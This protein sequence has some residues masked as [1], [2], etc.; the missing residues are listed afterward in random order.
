MEKHLRG[1]NAAVAEKIRALRL[2]VGREFGFLSR[3]I[4]RVLGPVLLWSTRREERRLAAGTTYE[5]TTIIER[6]NWGLPET[7]SSAFPPATAFTAP[8]EV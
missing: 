3:V 6:R 2:D 8:E 1:A 4:S 5:P 7:L